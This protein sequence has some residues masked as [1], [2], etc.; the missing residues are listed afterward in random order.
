MRTLSGGHIYVSI[1]LPICVHT[2]TDICPYGYRYVSIRLPIYMSSTTICVS[3]I[4]VLLLY[5]FTADI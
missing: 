2:A 4:Y 1:R 5:V 3:D